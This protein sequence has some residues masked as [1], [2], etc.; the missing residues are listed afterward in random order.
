MGI[1]IMMSWCIWMVK[2]HLIFIGVQPSIENYRSLFHRNLLWF[3]YTG[4]KESTK[5]HV[6]T[7]KH[8]IDKHLMFL[9]IYISLEIFV[10]SFTFFDL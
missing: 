10:N 2:N 4:K 5:P 9:F 8:N 1:V 7:D 3:Y 6:F